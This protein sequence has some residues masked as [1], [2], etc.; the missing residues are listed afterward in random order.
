MGGAKR[1]ME[2]QH[3][4]QEVGIEIGVRAGVLERCD[5]HEECYWG[6]GEDEREAYKIASVLIRDQDELVAG[7]DRQEILDGVKAAIADAGF[8]GCAHCAKN[9]ADD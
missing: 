4:A 6:T 9:M 1:M 5:G 8:D 7:F 3:A 2:Q